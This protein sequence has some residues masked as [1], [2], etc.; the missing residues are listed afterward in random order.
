MSELLPTAAAEDD[1]ASLRW[2]ELRREPTHVQARK[3]LFRNTAGDVAVV[4]V[5]EMEVGERQVVVDRLVNAV[6][7]DIGGFFKSIR[8]RFDEANVGFPKVE[9]R[10]ENLRVDA[11]VRF[12]S[13]A[14]PT[15]PNFL[16][17]LPEVFLRQL[18]IFH[19][20]RKQLS[21]LDNV[22]G[23][24]RPSRLTLLLGPPSSGKTTLLLALAGRLQPG[25]QM[26]GEVTYNG[27]ELKEFVPQRTSAYVSQQDWHIAEMTVREILEFSRH[28]QGVGSMHSLLLELLE[29]EKERKILPDEDLD[30][31][32]K[33]LA[34]REAKN[35]LA[36][37][38]VMKDWTFVRTH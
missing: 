11:F 20:K 16:L 33:A 38:F 25:L 1:E 26:S 5:G 24:V 22:T 10:F 34:L 37:E 32:I 15:I 9:V 12:G 31:F 29:R 19:G 13:R 23:I 36:V 17:S 14:L 18:R 21:I 7:Q 3:G 6:N 27:H 8:E 2:A 30:I 4:D 28:C 35:S